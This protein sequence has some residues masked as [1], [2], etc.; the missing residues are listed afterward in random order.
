VLSR[1][2]TSVVKHHLARI[3]IL[4]EKALAALYRKKGTVSR[5]VIDPTSFEMTL[6]ANNQVILAELLSAGE[7]QLLATGLLWALA[8]AAGRP[9]PTVID[10][11]L[12]RLDSEHRRNLIKSY[13]PH[14]SHQVI[15]LSTDE[16]ITGTYYETLKPVISRSF[17]LNFDERTRSSR[18][19]NGYAFVQ[20]VA[21]VH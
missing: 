2:A 11:P 21:H 18:V 7:R 9:I 8:Q 5:V 14:A 1:F 4:I 3:E 6:R 19:D 15:L 20:K 12:G 17:T 13:F 16:E 10:T